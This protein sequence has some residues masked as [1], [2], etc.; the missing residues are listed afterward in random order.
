MPDGV[1]AKKK[2]RHC[3]QYLANPENLSGLNLPEY[4]IEMLGEP[5]IVSVIVYTAKSFEESQ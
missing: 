5:V 3:W 4:I 1:I 2:A